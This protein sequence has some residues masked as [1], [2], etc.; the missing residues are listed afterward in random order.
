MTLQVFFIHSWKL[1]FA[2]FH[3]LVEFDVFGRLHAENNEADFLLLEQK[4]HWTRA[5]LSKL[6]SL[7]CSIKI[8]GCQLNHKTAR[9]AIDEQLYKPADAAAQQI[10]DSIEQTMYNGEGGR[11][12]RVSTVL[13]SENNGHT[14][15]GSA[16]GWRMKVKQQ[17]QHRRG[18]SQTLE[19]NVKHEWI[20]NDSIMSLFAFLQAT[21]RTYHFIVGTERHKANKSRSQMAGFPCK[22][23]ASS[24]TLRQCFWTQTQK[25]INQ[26]HNTRMSFVRIPT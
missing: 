4:P 23:R 18:C 14:Q 25:P 6:I 11:V 12:S 5:R 20:K 13:T 1:H 21:A 2:S 8:N 16:G 9:R 17:Q 22:W 19:Q 10:S 24:H 7:C 3:S 15:S 26:K